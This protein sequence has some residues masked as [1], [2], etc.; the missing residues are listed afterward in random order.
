M[1]SVVLLVFQPP[2]SASGD[3][4]VSTIPDVEAASS[5]W[6]VDDDKGMLAVEIGKMVRSAVA[7]VD[8]SVEAE[9]T[10][11]MVDIDL[12]VLDTGAAVVVKA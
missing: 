6:V 10:N 8:V 11:T 1:I 7:S 12:N 2:V 3:I 9:D 4:V 5:S